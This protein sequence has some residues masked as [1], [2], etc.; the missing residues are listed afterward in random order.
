MKILFVGFY[1]AAGRKIIEK[2]CA[3]SAVTE[4]ILIGEDN[5]QIENVRSRF[6]HRRYFRNAQVTKDVVRSCR[7]LDAD[8]YE[9]MA[10]YE[11]EFYQ[12]N[13]R[14][15]R[16]HTLDLYGTRREFYLR[17]LAYF[18][19]LLEVESFDAVILS[20]IPHT[21]YDLLLYG[22]ARCK[23]LPV[24]CFYR[25]PIIPDRF[26]YLYSLENI[27]DH[28][29]QQLRDLTRQ[30]HEK[31]VSEKAG[32]RQ[33]LKDS[34]NG[35]D[36][37]VGRSAR[38]GLSPAAQPGRSAPTILK[39]KLTRLF[40]RLFLRTASTV[41]L[42][43]LEGYPGVAR[44][45]GRLEKARM[46]YLNQQCEQY[47]EIHSV[48]PVAGETYVYFPLH[49]Q[50]EATTGPLG[51]FFQ[52]QR[53]AIDML[54]KCLPAGWKIYVKE[55]PHQRLTHRSR[56]YYDELLGMDNVRLIK[57]DVN[58]IELVKGSAF[59]ATVTGTAAWEAFWLE[60]PAVLFG[61]SL[62]CAAKG[63][64]DVKTA[65]DLRGVLTEIPS[66][67]IDEED[68]M[69]WLFAVDQLAFK[70]YLEP[71]KPAV[72]NSAFSEDENAEAVSREICSFLK[73]HL[74]GATA[75]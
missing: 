61:Y 28:R 63:M 47:Y 67:C 7:P 59:V 46:K 13:E 48:R 30:Y 40:A 74:G 44:K 4:Y 14:I 17:S 39:E 62:L 34:I 1:G 24:L 32:I 20:N 50:P 31:P 27:Y 23:H 5:H 22:L 37:I 70:A 21:N 60:K 42:N 29:A 15:N 33:R 68:R 18:N 66:V 3:K 12:Q 9:Q 36:E 43:K 19:D 53:Q 10:R 58:S 8:L 73:K 56:G 38:V 2:T 57:K 11:V 71:Y 26:F 16:T 55:F 6:L 49:K 64:F 52:D 72:Q 75:S 45:R 65:S 69:A 51:G 54:S 41:R 35:W 25:T